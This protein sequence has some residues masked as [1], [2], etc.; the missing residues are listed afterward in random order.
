MMNAQWVS[1]GR[2]LWSKARE[3]EGGQVHGITHQIHDFIQV[4]QHQC[5]VQVNERVTLCRDQQ[6]Q[7]AR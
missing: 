2:G 4:I 1:D 7:Q 5:H 6:R 3:R